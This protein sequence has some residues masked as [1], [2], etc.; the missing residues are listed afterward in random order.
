MNKALHALVYVILILAVVALVF[1]LNLYKKRELLGARNRSLEDFVVS[2]AKTIETEDAP[3]SPT[4]PEINKDIQ[5]VEAKAV[6]S[7]DMENLLDEYPSHLEQANLATFD[8][9]NTKDRLQLRAY[10][11]LDPVTGMPIPDPVNANKPTTEGPGTM[12][13]LLSKLFDRATKQQAKLNST[14]AELVHMRD[15]LEATVTELNKLKQEDRADK[16]TIEE[17]KAKIAQLE[18]AKATLEEQVSQLKS[19]IEELNGQITSLKDEV[20]QAKDETEAVKEEL[21][22][23][24]KKS[25]QLNKML[26]AERNIRIKLPQG[27]GNGQTSTA[28]LTT[29][30][31]GKLV[32]VNN[33]LMFAVVEFTDAAMKELLGP[34]REGALPM[35]ELDVKR[36]GFNGPA[37]E[38][39]GR[40]RLRVAVEDKN[41]VIAD[42]LGDWE[43]DKAEAGDVVFMD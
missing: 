9:N 31:K 28:T 37:G 6:E 8:W 11:K 40:I 20:Q 24:K 13:E 12:K 33:D 39:I 36:K 43:Q 18:E 14:R 3:K 5:A 38:R 35:L 27:G 16:V 26:I 42:I 4:P 29:G 41:Y 21:E 7:P 34:N 30:E 2:I 17:L 25:Q 15:K 23:E 22:K 32:S 19:Q 1:E 10:Y